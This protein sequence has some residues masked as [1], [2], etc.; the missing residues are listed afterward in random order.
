MEHFYQN[1]H[2]WFSAETLYRDMVAEAGDGAVFVE[3]GAWKG[4]SAAYLAVE[5][6]N[7]GKD[8]KLH[9]VDWFKGSDEPA[10]HADPD[11]REGR[12]RAVFEANMA[13][14]ASVVT[15][16][17]MTSVEAASL[18]A[19]DSLDFVFIDADHTYAGAKQDILTWR[20]KVKPGKMLAGDDFAYFPGVRQAVEELLPGH[21][22][23][24][25]LWTWRKPL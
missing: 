13:P 24:H 22:T 4:R 18:F 14:V 9:V 17:A 10:H 5:I 15:T 19:D 3:V 2:G 21:Q 6:V 23:P 25:P 16:H 20:A 11:V 1:I 7:S 12:L 8:V